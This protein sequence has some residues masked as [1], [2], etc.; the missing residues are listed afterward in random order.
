MILKVTDDGLPFDPTVYES[1][2][3]D[4]IEFQ[5]DG[6]EMI[7]KLADKINYMRTLNLNNTIFELNIAK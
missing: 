3:K 5:T 1:S 7:K 2:N 6:I 4:D